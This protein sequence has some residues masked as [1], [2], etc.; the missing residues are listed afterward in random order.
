MGLQEAGSE[1]GSPQGADRE[2]LQSTGAH[3]SSP[4]RT[5]GPFFP[6]F[7]KG[8]AI[9]KDGSAEAAPGSEAGPGARRPPAL[10]G[11]QA[12]SQRDLE[13]TPSR[14]QGGVSLFRHR[15][16]ARRRLCC[17]RGSSAAL[18]PTG[19]LQGRRLTGCAFSEGGACAWAPDKDLW[20]PRVPAGG[21]PAGT[22]R[23]L[24]RGWVPRLP[25]R[26]HGLNSAHECCPD[27][28]DAQFLESLFS[29]AERGPSGRLCLP[30]KRGACEVQNG[31]FVQ[32]QS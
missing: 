6:H 10:P 30:P 29:D 25:C 4:G 31:T 13:T 27:L 19:H 24:P 16:A 1:T 28:A 32:N 11:Q 20:R 23:R 5:P 17:L 26:D 15:T 8:A 22:L 9:A 3:R 21:P 2:R 18:L 12:L 14:S 7:V